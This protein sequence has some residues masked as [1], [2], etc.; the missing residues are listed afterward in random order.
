[1]MMLGGAGGVQS[2]PPEFTGMNAF[3]AAAIDCGSPDGWTLQITWTITRANNALYSVRIDRATANGST[4]YSTPVI[5]DLDCEANGLYLHKTGLHGNPF[6]SEP[7]GTHFT[8]YQVRIIKRD[9]L[10]DVDAIATSPQ[11]STTYGVCL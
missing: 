8:R 10:S 1:M 5:A 3:E 9:D 2:D 11:I 4:D 6:S 7:E